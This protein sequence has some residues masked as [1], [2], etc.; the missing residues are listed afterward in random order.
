VVESGP[1]EL[2][3]VQASGPLDETETTTATQS[4]DIAKEWYA[5]VGNYTKGEVTFKVFAICE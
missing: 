4:G 2:F 1:P 3:D 5:A